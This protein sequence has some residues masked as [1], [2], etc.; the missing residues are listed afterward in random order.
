MVY[1]QFLITLRLQSILQVESIV[2]KSQVIILIEL[3]DS[4][5]ICHFPLFYCY[6]LTETQSIG[7]K[8]FV[9]RCSELTNDQKLDIVV[10]SIERSEGCASTSTKCALNQTLYCTGMYC[11]TYS[12][13]TPCIGSQILEL[14]GF[15][16]C[17]AIKSCAGSK[18]SSITKNLCMFGRCPTSFERLYI[19]AITLAFHSQ[20]RERKMISY[21]Q[22]WEH[23]IHSRSHSQKQE[24]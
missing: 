10:R 12:V 4:S 11:D 2:C 17:T 6:S 20:R 5:R 15:A 13:I 22:E 3:F 1:E 21:S 8:Y 18:T 9:I 7:Q 14:V 24:R 23:K 19:R 16:L